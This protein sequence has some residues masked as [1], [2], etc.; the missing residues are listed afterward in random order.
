MVVQYVG[1]GARSSGSKEGRIKAKE[2]L[3]WLFDQLEGL[4][5]V[6]V[7]EERDECTVVDIPANCIGYIGQAI[8]EGRFHDFIRTRG[9]SSVR[10]AVAGAWCV[11]P[12][13]PVRRGSRRRSVGLSG[14]TQAQ[15]A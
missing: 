14:A 3:K 11:V 8:A 15:D 6:G 12:A 4:V 9:P 7:W 5:Y 13:C 10:S 2:Y 1:H